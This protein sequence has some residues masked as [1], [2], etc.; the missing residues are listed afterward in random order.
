LGVFS[1]VALFLASLGI[2]G[3]MSFSVS[4]RTNEIGV[5]MALGAQREDILRLIFSQSARLVGVGLIVGVAGALAGSRLLRSLLFDVSPNDP[6][7]FAIIA[8]VLAAVAALASYLPA[9]R[10]TKVDPLVALRHE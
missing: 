9:R 7:T 4:Q 10:A 2:F 3:V 6:V 8:L 1:V 5:R